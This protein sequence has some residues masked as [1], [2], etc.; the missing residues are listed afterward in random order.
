MSQLDAT[1]K[2]N[3]DNV[4]RIEIAQLPHI[5]FMLVDDLGWNDIGYN[6][7]DMKGMVRFV[8]IHV[9]QRATTV[10]HSPLTSHHTPTQPDPKHG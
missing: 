3:T 6:S 2:L 9:N 10:H 1:Q 7:D 4:E 5:L 8:F